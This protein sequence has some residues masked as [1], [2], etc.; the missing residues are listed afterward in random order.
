VA[1]LALCSSGCLRR[2]HTVRMERHSEEV[3]R[4]IETRLLIE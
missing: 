1:V 3:I 4:T 2:T